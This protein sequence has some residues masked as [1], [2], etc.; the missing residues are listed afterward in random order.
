[1][2]V[3]RIGLDLVKNVFRAPE[4]ATQLEDE[5]YE[6]AKNLEFKVTTK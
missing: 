5:M 4:F 3:I 6:A 2:K 1:M